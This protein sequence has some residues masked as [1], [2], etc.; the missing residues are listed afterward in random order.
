VGLK[1]DGNYPWSVVVNGIRRLSFVVFPFLDSDDR[2]VGHN[3]FLF[4]KAWPSVVGPP[5][6]DTS[7]TDADDVTARQPAY[8]TS[9]KPR[10]GVGV[11][12]CQPNFSWAIRLYCTVV[13][14]AV[15][16][17][18]YRTSETENLNRYYVVLVHAGRRIR[19]GVAE[20][21]RG[22]G[23]RWF[24]HSAIGRLVGVFDWLF[25]SDNL[26]WESG[27]ER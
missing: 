9:P 20:G 6:F 21:G 2:V 17:N 23:C 16:I 27:C 26:F 4:A 24:R 19:R 15:L 5:H 13:Y 7:W 12:Q 10:V 25:F 22:E 3:D 11:C 8:T 18:I 1:Y 14:L